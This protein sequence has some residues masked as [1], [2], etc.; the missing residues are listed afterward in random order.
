MIM[1]ASA[2][3]TGAPGEIAE[4]ADPG[5]CRDF[6]H[7]GLEKRAEGVDERGRSPLEPM[8]AEK[9]VAVA[10]P[11]GGFL[12]RCERPHHKGCGTTGGNSTAAA[13]NVKVRERKQLHTAEVSLSYGALIAKRAEGF[14]A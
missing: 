8:S 13:R 3:A 1:M 2:C 4:G 10:Y 14:R 12:P 5:G 6:G 11:S 7:P 9:I